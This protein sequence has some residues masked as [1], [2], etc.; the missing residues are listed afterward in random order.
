LEHVTAAIIGEN[1]VRLKVVIGP[2][3]SE[4][5]EVV[6]SIGTEPHFDLWPAT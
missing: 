3:E 1:K 4:N 2:L 5:C 6:L